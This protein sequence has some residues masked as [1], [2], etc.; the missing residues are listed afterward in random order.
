[1]ATASGRLHALSPLATL[2]RGYAVARDAATHHPITRAAD[3]PA[4]AR[5]DLVLKDG[6]VRAMSEGSVPAGE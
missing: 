4:G 1:M 6:A 2:E 5:F 3:L